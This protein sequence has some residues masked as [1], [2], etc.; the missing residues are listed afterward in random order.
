M[1]SRERS[2]KILLVEDDPAVREILATALEDEGYTVICAINGQ[3]GLEQLSRAQPELVVTN[4]MMPG[5][6][7]MQM[8]RQL[9]REHD[10]LPV[11]MFS[12]TPPSESDECRISAYLRKPT[13]LS[14]L[15]ET[16]DRLLPPP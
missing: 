16:I 11:V 12:A 10:D 13:E 8:V 9:R 1:T 14:T 15:M 5:M 2:P 3:E 7:G 6:D 4:F